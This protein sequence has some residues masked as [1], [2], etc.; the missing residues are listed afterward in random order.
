MFEGSQGPERAV[1]GRYGQRQTG[2]VLIAFFALFSH[3]PAR[4]RRTTA[5]S[6]SSAAIKAGYRERSTQ[7]GSNEAAETGV[8]GGQRTN[9]PT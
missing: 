2:Q 6:T 4:R 3:N 8:A 7:C 9:R 1:A 5:D